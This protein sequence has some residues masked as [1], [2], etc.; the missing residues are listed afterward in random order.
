V[1][2][3]LLD[4]NDDLAILPGVKCSPSSSPSFRSNSEWW[5]NNRDNPF[6]FRDTLKA[7]LS[8]ETMTYSDLAV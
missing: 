8:V 6:L 2:N 3:G 4:A 7:L 5:Q 1:G